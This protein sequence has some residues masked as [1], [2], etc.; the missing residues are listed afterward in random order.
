VNVVTDDHIERY[1][2]TRSYADLHDLPQRV[3]TAV[4]ASIVLPDP[5]DPEG[6]VYS[7]MTTVYRNLDKQGAL[8]VLDEGSGV[9]SI[10]RQLIEKLTPPAFKA[11]AVESFPL[12][13]ECERKI[14]K[15]TV[16][17]LA[18]IGR[19]TSVAWPATSGNKRVREENINQMG[20]SAQQLSST[21]S[22]Q[23]S[24]KKARS[25]RREERMKA[26]RFKTQQKEREARRSR[27]EVDT[28]YLLSLRR[29][30]T[31]SPG[32]QYG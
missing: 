6:T 15:K 22:G 32:V 21:N 18:I 29:T 8:A 17:K 19:D 23:Q 28:S 27:V 12:W 16:Q 26:A 7:Y 9:K 2:E 5:G 30:W 4:A 11:A 1:L 13:H 24:K 20:T 25:D 10:V 3:R 31:R 14:W